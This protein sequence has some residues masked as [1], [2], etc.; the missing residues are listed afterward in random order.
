MLAMF[1]SRGTGDE[2]FIQADEVQ[3][4]TNL[5]HEAMEGLCGIVQSIWHFCVFEKAKGCDDGR[6]QK[7]DP[8]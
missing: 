8:V 6:L 2:Y 4:V 1:F 5:I 7:G 3:A